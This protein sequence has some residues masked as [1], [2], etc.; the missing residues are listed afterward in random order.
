MELRR[1]QTQATRSTTSNRRLRTRHQRIFHLQNPTHWALQTRRH[2]H[3][4]AQDHDK[5][6]GNWSYITLRG[7]GNSKLTFLTF[8]RVND[9]GIL[10]TATNNENGAK[11]SITCCTQQHQILHSERKYNINPR[12]LCLEELRTLIK[13]KFKDKNHHLIIGIDANED[14]EG[15]GPKS[16]KSIMSNLGLQNSL[17]REV[18][19]GKRPPHNRHWLQ[20]NR[21]HLLHRWSPPSHSIRRRILLRHHL[22]LQPPSPLP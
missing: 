14:M 15:I 9:Q 20:S 13:A 19:T 4:V 8:Y 6:L 3:V 18:N 10:P 17:A 22:P 21:P 16:L 12:N 2:S 7:K 1:W 5:R 11:E